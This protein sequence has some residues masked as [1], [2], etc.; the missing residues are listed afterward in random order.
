[1]HLFCWTCWTQTSYIT[2]HTHDWRWKCIG[3]IFS[4]PR[5]WLQKKRSKRSDLW[6]SC[7]YIVVLC[8]R[9]LCLFLLMNDRR[10]WCGLWKLVSILAVAGRCDFYSFYSMFY[11]SF[12]FIQ[13]S[14][15][16]QRQTHFHLTYMLQ[17]ALPVCQCC[18]KPK[19]RRTDRWIERERERAKS[20]SILIIYS[21]TEMDSLIYTVKFYILYTAIHCEFHRINNK[22]TQTENACN[23]I[24][25]LVIFNVLIL[26]H[27]HTFSLEIQSIE[28]KI[29]LKHCAW[30]F[31]AANWLSYRHQSQSDIGLI[32]ASSFVFAFTT[33]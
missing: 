1:M 4:I 29:T 32:R 22:K 24:W 7:A 18:L 27:M 13:F 14:I 33:I 21:C 9:F 26:N 20:L 8:I 17:C 2:L 25:L 11:F 30:I 31:I 10:S 5:F 19:W 6:F 12:I 23:D 3:Y 28:L 15:A 16:T